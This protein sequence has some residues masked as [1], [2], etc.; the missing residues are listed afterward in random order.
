MQSFSLEQW[1]EQEHDSGKQSQLKRKTAG[2]TGGR[3]NDNMQA[4]IWTDLAQ[5]P[6]LGHIV[7]DN[8]RAGTY[9]V[10]FLMKHI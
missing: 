3:H 4:M 5:A 2:Y 7:S 1:H 9:I 6:Q 8:L 10:E